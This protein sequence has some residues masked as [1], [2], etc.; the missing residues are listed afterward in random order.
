MRGIRAVRPKPGGRYRSQV[1]DTEIIVVRAPDDDVDLTCGG[2][3]LI[4]FGETPPD[5]LEPAPGLDTRTPTGKRY[6]DKAG[7]IEILVT[8]G[9]S[10]TLALG[11][12][13]M[14]QKVAKP[15]PSS[16]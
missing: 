12:V 8:R 1:G 6:V 13:P 10:G 16:D 11:S 14:A 9:G 15:L 2:Y 7:I 5:G 4:G 3:P